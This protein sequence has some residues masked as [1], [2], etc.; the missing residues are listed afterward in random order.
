MIDDIIKIPN[1]TSNNYNN[2]WKIYEE[3]YKDNSQLNKF[4]K[5]NTFLNKKTANDICNDIEKIYDVRYSFY[6]KK[7]SY[8]LSYLIFS[9][10]NNFLKDNVNII[11]NS[12]SDFFKNGE[13][14]NFLKIY[15]K[16]CIYSDC[17][18]LNKFTYEIN[19]S[20]ENLDNENSF[21]KFQYYL[22][23]LLKIVDKIDNKDKYLKSNIIKNISF[24]YVDKLVEF[25]DKNGLTYLSNLYNQSIF[26]NLFKEELHISY[27]YQSVARNFIKYLIFKIINFSYDSLTNS[28]YANEII[29]IIKIIN[30]SNKI[31][32]IGEINIE[33][34]ID[35]LNKFTNYIC[36]S[37]YYFLNEKNIN[38]VYDIIE[39]YFYN[40]QNKIDFL[41]FY[42]FHLQWRATNKL[43]FYFEN[44][45]FKFIK[46]IF[47]DNNYKKILDNI[48]NSLDDIYLSEHMNDEIKNLKIT[49]E[50]PEYK[51]IEFNNN[52]VNVFISSNVIWND[53]K[54][55]N[56]YE[57]VLK[58]KEVEF[59]SKLV[60]N[61]YDK[62]YNS[63]EQN[64]L[65]EISYD[66]SF[67]D[68]SLGNSNIRLPITYLT[69]L[70]VIGNN[71]DIDFDSIL[72][73]SNIDL[74][75][76]NIIIN[77]FKI[78]NI[79]IEK[80]NK[81]KFNTNFL[82][83]KSD[84]NMMQNINSVNFN[85]IDEVIEYDKDMMIDSVIAKVCKSKYINAENANVS[86]GRLIMEVRNEL[87]R[88]FIPDEKNINIRLNR[89]ETLGYILKD[90]NL[91][92]FKYI[93]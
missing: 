43:N 76:L 58:S 4:I 61:Y 86:Y 53:L 21:I 13:M 60:T 82:N 27:F 23:K 41:T 51:N 78:L 46:N 38:N 3:S 32:D 55:S 39:F 72:R 66:E 14:N 18:I 77:D 67:V 75:K 42:K 50:T 65:L 34:N 6:K 81:F 37:L 93:P 30:I 63:S 40:L 26:L 15:L 71:F 68:A 36:A 85:I 25:T 10:Y 70:E 33:N 22:N 87:N 31:L 8:V 24:G 29:N 16:S 64:R 45:A 91:N 28:D 44:E 5:S 2:Y 12:V 17:R 47:V 69:V 79:V 20:L 74:D 80:S 62:K 1:R 59:Y 92:S 9:Y 56:N 89:L 83:S 48:K 52:K 11:N 49:I 54:K 84:I 57:N 19:L 88:F 90:E 35:N 7:S 73:K